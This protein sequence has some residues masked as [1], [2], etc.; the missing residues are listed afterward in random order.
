MK[1]FRIS[2]LLFFFTMILMF[3]PGC[4]APAPISNDLEGIPDE[5]DSKSD[6]GTP[7]PMLTTPELRELGGESLPNS[8]EGSPTPPMKPGEYKPHEQEGALAGVSRI[9]PDKEIMLTFDV[10]PELSE[11]PGGMQDPPNKYEATVDGER[12]PCERWP[13]TPHRIYCIGP[14]LQNNVIA[15]VR[16]TDLTTG[17]VLFEGSVSIVIPD[18]IEGSI[19]VQLCSG[20]DQLTCMSRSDCQW[21]ISKVPAR[22]EP[23]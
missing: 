11:S 14:L 19:P 7:A 9:A 17:A 15:L 6:S 23:H 20:L 22:C 10:P 21:I 1:V 4:K 16:L 3:T 13:E 2:M 5:N 18:E 12:F 8:E